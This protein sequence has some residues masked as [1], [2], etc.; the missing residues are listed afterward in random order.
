MDRQRI[1][2]QT[3]SRDYTEICSR[4][5][6]GITTLETAKAERE[7]A[8]EQALNT[9]ICIPG[10]DGFDLANAMAL[11]EF[12]CA[13]ENAA[14]T[15][16]DQ[17]PHLVGDLDKLSAFFQQPEVN[18]EKPR[19]WSRLISGRKPKAAA[20]LSTQESDV[21][22]QEAFERASRWNTLIL[23]DISDLVTFVDDMQ[24]KVED[25][26]VEPKAFVIGIVQRLKKQAAS[27]EEVRKMEKKKLY[28]E[29]AISMT[30]KHLT[31]LS[32]LKREFSDVVEQLKKIENEN[33]KVEDGV[34]NIFHPD[35]VEKITG[36]PITAYDL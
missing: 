25:A 6:A 34:M 4:I 28:A 17:V 23:K 30:G 11:R 2:S 31:E 27:E 1:L 24:E 15:L 22:P 33:A 9:L 32:L 12:F 19:F 36:K 35:D 16:R 7:R 21:N 3:M 29:E 13:S 20:A 14:A 10:S 26:L 5:E 8:A 18:T